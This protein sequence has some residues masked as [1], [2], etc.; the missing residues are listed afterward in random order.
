M[1]WVQRQMASGVDPRRILSRFLPSGTVIPPDID[2]LT[3]WRIIIEIAEPP[4]RDKLPDVN[5]MDDV[6]RLLKSSQRIM[7]LTGAGVRNEKCHHSFNFEG[8]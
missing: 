2:G 5:T 7:V 6:I 1:V 3:L 4:R 8:S